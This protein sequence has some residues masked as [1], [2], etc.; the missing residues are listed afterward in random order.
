[1]HPRAARPGFTLLELMLVVAIIG[2]LASVALP[3]YGTYV[4]K[5]KVAEGFAL[6]EP[7]Q[8]A[9]VAYYDRW[10]VLPVDNAAAGLPAP[11]AMRGNW[12][13]SVRVRDGAVLVS[14]TPVRGETTPTGLLALRP[15]IN[16]AAPTQALAWTCGARES[17]TAFQMAASMPDDPMPQK[18]LPGTCR[19]S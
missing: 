19:A 3:A 8:K 1:M 16:R 5:A 9:V 14:F 11:E 4:R 2:I 6:A 15:G 18:F 17:P 13:A 7:A 12:V 10:G